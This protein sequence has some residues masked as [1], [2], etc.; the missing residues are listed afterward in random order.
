MEGKGHVQTYN[1]ASLQEVHRGSD[2][3]LGRDG[4]EVTLRGESGDSSR[5]PDPHGSAD[6]GVVPNHNPPPTEGIAP[7][8]PRSQSQEF[9]KKQTVVTEVDT[10]QYIGADDGSATNACKSHVD[11]F[12][13]DSHPYMLFLNLY[14]SSSTRYAFQYI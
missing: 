14:A 10:L 4:R 2:T 3:V 7:Q 11:P 5:G 13:G 8:P 6:Q 9:K 12:K 1:H